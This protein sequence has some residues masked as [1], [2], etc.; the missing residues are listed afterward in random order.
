MNT[1][2]SQSRLQDDFTAFIQESELAQ[3]FLAKKREELTAA[4]AER[5]DAKKILQPELDLIAATL[6]ELNE[7][8]MAALERLECEKQKI[9]DETYASAKLLRDRRQTLER[10]ISER[11]SFLLTHYEPAIDEAINYFRNK[12]DELRGSRNQYRDVSQGQK[13]L[14]DVVKVTIRSNVEAIRAACSYCQDAVKELETMKI[15]QAAFDSTIVEKLKE[16]IPDHR[17]LTETTGALKLKYGAVR[18]IL[19]E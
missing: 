8:H 16:G 14:N 13:N 2:Q 17:L 11:D 15:S 6:T 7:K 3:A 9:Y 5:I 18:D 12:Q 1:V 4:R 10:E 19:G